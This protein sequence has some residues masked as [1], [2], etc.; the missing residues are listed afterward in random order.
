VVC[1]Y[2]IWKTKILPKKPPRDFSNLP[3]VASNCY[4]G[5]FQHA[6]QWLEDRKS[7]QMSYEAILGSAQTALAATKLNSNNLNFSYL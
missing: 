3:E 7:R 2:Y 1:D 5:A 6:P 4:I